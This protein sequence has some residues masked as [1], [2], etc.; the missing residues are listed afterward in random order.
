MYASPPQCSNAADTYA[1]NKERS[2]IHAGVTA[3][4]SITTKSHS[5]IGIVN[6]KFSSQM[7]ICDISVYIVL[8]LK[9]NWLQGMLH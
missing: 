5:G 8:E 6:R 3:I 9:C 4:P 1:C 7:A 2:F